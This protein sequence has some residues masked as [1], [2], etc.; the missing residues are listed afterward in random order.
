MKNTV[1]WDVSRV[2]LIRTDVSEDDGILN[3]MCLLPCLLAWS[4][5]PTYITVVHDIVSTGKTERL[6]S[7]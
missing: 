6:T 1:F 5:L 2:A 3:S 4:V 7:E